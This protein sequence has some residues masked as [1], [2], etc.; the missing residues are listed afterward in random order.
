V[1]LVNGAEFP[2]TE[3]GRITLAYARPNATYKITVK[4]QPSNPAQLCTV[5]NGEGKV[6]QVDVLDVAITCAT[7]HRISGTVTGE[8]PA[9]VTLM[10]SGGTSAMS[11]ADESGAYA[12]DGLVDGN[13]VVT[14][15]LAGYAFQPQNQAVS[16][17]A[18][19]ATGQDF[20]E[21]PVSSLCGDGF[22]NSDAEQCDQGA[23]NSNQGDCLLICRW[24]VCGDGF[25]NQS[26]S[27]RD[28]ETCDDGP[29]NGST[30]CLYGQKSCQVCKSDCSGYETGKGGYCGDGRTDPA[31]G[32]ACDDGGRNGAATCPY[33]QAS[34]QICK[35]DCS[36]YVAGTGPYC[37]DKIKN[38]TEACDDG[39]YNGLTTCPYGTKSCQHCNATCSG[40][41]SG[42]PSYCG[43]GVADTANGEACDDGDKNGSTT[44]LYGQASCKNCNSTCTGS[45]NGHGSYCGDGHIDT[46]YGETC[47][48]GAQNGSA[49]CPSGVTSCQLCSGICTAMRVGGP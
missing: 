37:G 4:T 45:V 6:G 43:D 28:V 16:V 29:R 20:V 31:N 38:D 36:G 49:T 46:A 47:D 21:I 27:V 11:K 22:V 32:E 9:G 5:V 23:R 15:V 40:Y 48:A 12:F 25:V 30:T 17:A 7:L 26:N 42:K 33:G 35:A 41:V 14:P 2:V 18:A 34:C 13:Y 8:H 44:C 3:G 10:L 19:D 24:N 39:L 1:L